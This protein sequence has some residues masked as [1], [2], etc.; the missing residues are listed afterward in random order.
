MATLILVR[1][2]Q[3]QWNLEG[4]FTGWVDID[5][6]ETG[7]SEARRAGQL[8]KEIGLEPDV[9]YASVLKRAIRT[10]EIS[11]E[12]MDR[13]WIPIIRNWRLNE[14]H[15]GALQG[16]NKAET[17]EQYGNEQVHLWRRSFDVPPPPL[18]R[19]DPTSSRNDPRYRTLAPELIP[20]TECLKD[21]LDR[22]LPFWY[23][24]LA[25]DLLQGKTPLVSAHGNSL[26][27]LVKHLENIPDDE[28]TE[29]EIPNG[30]PIIYEFDSQL[31]VIS[32]KVL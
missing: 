6:T 25:P 20:D 7:V 4:L 12:E 9:C 3:S 31:R 23:D 5:I 15:Y 24:T 1:H 29:Y 22:M 21:V 14:R 2:G 11:L 28:I 10:A 30:E 19:S 16:L 17:A 18:D 27:A 13:L 26:R 8:L 32:K